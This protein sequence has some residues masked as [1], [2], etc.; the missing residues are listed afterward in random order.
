[1]NETRFSPDDRLRALLRQGDPAG[2]DPGLTREEAGRMRRAILNAA[3]EPRRRPLWLPV[4]AAAAV[5]ALTLAI[6]LGL[7]RARADFSVH[8]PT[9]SAAVVP[10]PETPV[11]APTP[12][13]PVSAAPE[14]APA[15]TPSLG[16]APAVRP[17]SRHPR[18]A[19]TP[20]PVRFA[21]L[22]TPPAPAEEN[23]EPARQIQFSTPGGTRV[24]WV[25]SHETIVE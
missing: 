25:L 24:I 15:A 9:R 12:S 14:A 5:G 22:P 8:E 18:R 20:G 10:T 23:E 16:K 1:M 2:D 19:A 21:S 4:L 13:L 11:P 3:P 6:A 7:W 17:R